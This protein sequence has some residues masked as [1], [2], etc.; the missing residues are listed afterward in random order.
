[1]A[2]AA[3]VSGDVLLNIRIDKG[4]SVVNIEVTQGPPL[5]RQAAIDAVKQWKYSLTLLNDQPTDVL[6]QVIVN[7]TLGQ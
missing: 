2:R 7:F 5:L 1:V 4:G 6:T 3:G